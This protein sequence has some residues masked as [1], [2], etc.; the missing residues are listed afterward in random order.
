MGIRNWLRRKLSLSATSMRELPGTP[1]SQYLL[2]VD[3]LPSREYSPRWGYSRPIHSGLADLF[4]LNQA[5]YVDRLAKLA[6]LQPYF[7]RINH[8]YSHAAA[9]EPAWTGGPITA[10][11]AAWIYY[12]MVTLRPATYLE[13]G[14]GISTLFAARAKKD[15]QLPTQ[16]VSIDPEP[17]AAV[18]GVCDRV[19][20][21]SLE[22]AELGLFGDLAAGDI[23]FLDGSH[24]AFMNSDVTVFMLDVLP[25][26]KP[27]VVV[28]VHDFHLPY[29]YPQMFANW[30]WNEQYCLGSYL[31]AMGTRVK[32]LM[33]GN[34][35]AQGTALRPIL[36]P[37]LSHWQ[38][39][40]ETWLSSGSIW[41]TRAD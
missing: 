34:Y 13:I 30:Y 35:F 16:I 10:L 29:D 4:S 38:Y 1:Y 21:A 3:Y 28:Q 23:V 18:D 8:A 17:R 15:H 27:G 14:S 31:M 33:P 36:E 6:T 26:L 9:T 7:N 11:D 12:F 41:F 20:R 24:R 32:V 19:I 2:P 40:P 5:E 37:V 22:T 39:A 25:L